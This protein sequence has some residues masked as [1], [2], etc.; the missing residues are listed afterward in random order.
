ML[1]G[2]DFDCAL[3]LISGW[4]RL[5]VARPAAADRCADDCRRQ[6]Q[7]MIQNDIAGMTRVAGPA[8]T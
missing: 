2:Y 7:A 4:R 6:E 1:E 3:F 8:V 5:V